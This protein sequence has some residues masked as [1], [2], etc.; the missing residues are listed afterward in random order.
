MDKYV[1]KNGTK[2]CKEVTKINFSHYLHGE[3]EG[4]KKA[5]MGWGLL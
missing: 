5:E 4:G 2:V 3:R 1:S